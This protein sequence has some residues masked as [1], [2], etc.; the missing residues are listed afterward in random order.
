L[1]EKLHPEEEITSIIFVRHGHTEQTEQGKLYCDHEARLTDMGKRQARALTARLTAEKPAV[2]L[3]STARRVRETAGV[4]SEAL[5]L[6]LALLPGLE[7]QNVGAWEDKTYLD[8]KKT[9][10]EEY[11]RWLADPIRNRPPD[12]ESI[13]D[14]YLRV[15]RE[16]ASLTTRYRGEKVILVSHAGVIRS[17]IVAALGMPVDNFWRISVPT[18]SASKIDYSDSFA[19]LCYMALQFE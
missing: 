13:E 4:L 12:G 16:L 2:L 14:L 19:T 6:P 15:S 3:A 11:Q 18:G 1:S 9:N 10:P 17:A 8:I 7:E 5:S